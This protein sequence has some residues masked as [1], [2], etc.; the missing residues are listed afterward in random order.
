VTAA[1][2]DRDVHRRLV[3]PGADASLLATLHPVEAQLRRLAAV[4]GGPEPRRHAAEHD[5]I[6]D[7][8]ADGDHDLA[9]ARLRAHL[10]ARLPALLDAAGG[11]VAA[12]PEPA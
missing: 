10:A 3:E 11:R 6:I 9:A 2:A 4:L 7:A 5:A 8:L 12:E 1:I